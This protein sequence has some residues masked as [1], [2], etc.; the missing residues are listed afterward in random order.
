M[1]TSDGTLELKD[2]HTGKLD[3]R[4][5]EWGS[6]WDVSRVSYPQLEALL[7]ASDAPK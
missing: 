6:A 3:I 2:K 1:T 7:E 5:A 4:D